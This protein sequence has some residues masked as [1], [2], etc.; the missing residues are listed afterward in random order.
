MRGMVAPVFS[1]VTFWIGIFTRAVVCIERA[2]GRRKSNLFRYAL[3]P[4]GVLVRPEKRITGI[5]LRRTL[6]L[7]LTNATDAFLQKV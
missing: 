5:S 1:V 6:V 3:N 2:M 4:R 7:S